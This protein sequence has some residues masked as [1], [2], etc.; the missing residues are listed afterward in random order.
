[1]RRIPYRFIALLVL[2]IATPAAAEE[3]IAA[4]IFAPVTLKAV[5]SHFASSLKVRV[6]L[7]ALPGVI[8]GSRVK[9]F[10]G[11]ATL[12]MQGQSRMSQE[13]TLLRERVEVED[14]VIESNLAE[15]KGLFIGAH[16]EEWLRAD[17]GTIRLFHTSARVNEGGLDSR[18]MKE[19]GDL[20]HQ[21][22]IAEPL[23]RLLLSPI[24]DP[25]R[26]TASDAF[27]RD[28]ETMRSQVDTL[29]SSL[30]QGISHYGDNVLMQK[31]AASAALRGEMLEWKSD[32]IYQGRVE[33]DGA[34][35]LR[36]TGGFIGMA[37]IVDPQVALYIMAREPAE[38]LIDPDT[39][40]EKFI[41]L[42]YAVMA[43]NL[44]HEVTSQCL[45]A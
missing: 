33:Q 25:D 8:T 29:I 17:D 5:D 2:A 11:A 45:R 19:A 6:T 34:E 36:F 42:Q 12:R 24:F 13:G 9:L 7:A 20:F 30:E 1:M 15:F 37:L 38:I 16:A 44:R 28:E 4:P 23:V 31:L 35:Y 41:R 22:Q 43:T 21:T 3:D 39:G 26:T 10:D 18:L 40:H 14:G 32:L 27:P